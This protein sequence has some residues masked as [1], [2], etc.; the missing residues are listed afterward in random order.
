MTD[1]LPLKSTFLLNFDAALEPAPI[2]VGAA[3]EGFRMIANVS[4][5]TVDGPRVK[6]EILPSGGDWLLMRGDGSGRLDVR[7]AF[8]THDGV[9]IYVTYGGRLVLPPEHQSALG[10]PE[11]SEALDPSLYYFRSNPVF[12]APMDSDYAWLNHVV[13]I[14]VGR[15]K[16]GGVAYSVHHIL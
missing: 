14:G 16:A 5:G 13:A 2:I 1:I 7:S 10:D 11:A 9:T 6:G 4:G 12:E 8:R 15:L 3:P